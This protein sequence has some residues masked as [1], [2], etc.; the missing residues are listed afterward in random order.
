MNSRLPLPPRQPGRPVTPLPRP[1]LQAD[2]DPLFEGDAERE[3][4][5]F[6]ALGQ[7]VDA[8]LLRAHLPWRHGPVLLSF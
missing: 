7:R 8:S 5:A 2:P 4:Q 3:W 1:C 6:L